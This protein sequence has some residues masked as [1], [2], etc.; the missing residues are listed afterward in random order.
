MR[1]AVSAAVLGVAAVP[2]AASAADLSV[3]V[4]IPKLSVAEYHKPYVALWIETPDQTAVKTLAVWYDVKKKDDEG[5][6]WLKDMRSWWRKAGREMKLPADGITGATKAPGR[7][8][9]VFKSGAAPLGALPAGDYVLV[10]EAAREVGG[11][12]TLRV[13]FQWPPKAAKSGSVQGSSELGAVIVA[14]KP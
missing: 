9:V 5:K 1:L 8:Q 4:E 12:E 13:P 10:A 11:R 3:T 2:A 14:V 6:T 7:Q